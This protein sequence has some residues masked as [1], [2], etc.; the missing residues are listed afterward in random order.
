MKTDIDAIARE[1]AGH[2]EA[3]RAALDTQLIDGNALDT[4]LCSIETYCAVSLR[5]MRQTNPSKV[6]DCARTVEIKALMDGVEI[7]RQAA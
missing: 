5:V 1:I 7:V 2:L 3:I 6:R 4:A